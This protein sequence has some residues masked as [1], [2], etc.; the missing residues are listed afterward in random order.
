M[1]KYKLVKISHLCNYDFD[2]KKLSYILSWIKMRL[3]SFISDLLV[4]LISI[5]K[6]E[7]ICASKTENFTND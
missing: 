4:I 3:L 2:G 5:S 7:N 6:L 1:L